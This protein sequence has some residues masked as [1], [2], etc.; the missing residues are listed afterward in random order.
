MGSHTST[1]SQKN[2]MVINFAQSRVL[3]DFSHTVS[4]FQNTSHSHRINPCGVIQARFREK[5]VMVM[6]FT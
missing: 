2:M 6:N 5:N 1:V 4:K 3:I